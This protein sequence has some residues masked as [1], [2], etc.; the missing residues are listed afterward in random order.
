MDN[1]CWAVTLRTD[2]VTYKPFM[3]TKGSE[4]VWYELPH[5]RITREA[6]LD[7]RKGM[8]ESGVHPDDILIWRVATETELFPKEI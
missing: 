8:L 1:E 3:E 5:C 2:F 6:A 4:G 7:V